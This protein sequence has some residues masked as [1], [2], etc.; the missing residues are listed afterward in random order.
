MNIKQRRSSE[1]WG[2]E[3]FH[4][5]WDF[6]WFKSVINIMFRLINGIS[7]DS[8]H[9]LWLMTLIRRLMA[10][11][12]DE[13]TLER[14]Y[15][16]VPTGSPQKVPQL[17]GNCQRPPPL[18]AV[19]LCGYVALWLCNCVAMWLY[20]YV[21]M[22]LCGYVAK[23]SPYPSAFRFPPLHPTTFLGDTMSSKQRRPSELGGNEWA[24]GKW[25]MI[26]YRNSGSSKNNLRIWGL[27]GLVG[28]F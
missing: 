9:F 7:V 4:Y 26:S 1:L 12:M 2:N 16:I 14:A 24:W 5:S 25:V 11:R 3:W 20:G 22:W 13:P 18:V 27:G 10:I 21:A 28:R 23:W 8:L 6:L 17:W 19:Y 15:W